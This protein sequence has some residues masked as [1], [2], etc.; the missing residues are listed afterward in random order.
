MKDFEAAL[1]WLRI[2]GSEQMNLLDSVSID[3]AAYPGTSDW[4]L[5]HGIIK[6][7]LKQTPEVPL[8]WIYGNPGTGKSAITAELVNWLQASN[9]AVVYHFCAYTYTSSTQYEGIIR[10]LLLQI[11]RNDRDVVSH[12]YQE[13]LLKRKPATVFTLEKLLQTAILAR[14]HEARQQQYLWIL[15]DAFSECENSKQQQL[16]SLLRQLSSL[17]ANQNVVKVVVTTRKLPVTT[18]RLKK[19]QILSLSDEEGPLTSAIRIYASRRLKFMESKLRQIELEEEEIHAIEGLVAEKAHGMF[20]YAR[21][22]LDYI[23]SNIFYD[24]NELRASIHQLPQTLA[25]FYNKLL[26]QILRNL[27]D[28]SQSRVQAV[29]N[30]VG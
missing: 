23:S 10:S 6:S 24:G 14:S 9:A 3:K 30:W 25:E 16:A 15:L 13:Y 21:L 22:V 26:M 28:R 17:S 7:W 20:L 8:I 4:L 12:V 19:S 5:Q 18:K 29:F 2:D 1:A 27:D 11:L